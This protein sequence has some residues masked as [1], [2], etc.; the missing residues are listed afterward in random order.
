MVLWGSLWVRR[1]PGC[2][3]LNDR[4]SADTAA[5]QSPGRAR[6]VTRCGVGVVRASR[7]TDAEVERPIADR[8]LLS[9]PKSARRSRQLSGKG[10]DHQLA[11]QL[12]GEG[13]ELY[14]QAVAARSQ[15]T[16]T[17]AMQR[18]IPGG[19]R[20]VRRLPPVA[21]LI[22]PWKKT[23]CFE[24]AR[25]QFFADR[26]CQSQRV[27]RAAAQEVSQFT[28]SRSRRCSPFPD[29][30]VLDRVGQA[31]GRHSMLGLNL[32]D[33]QRPW[34][35]TFGHAVRIYDRMRLDDPTGKLADD[36]TIAAANALFA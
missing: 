31:K 18:F 20:Q 33:K 29:R 7:R 14:R 1:F 26:V 2:A 15:S 32:T 36:A 21:G 30:P 35:D 27:F 22:L 25:C 4:G 3:A 9:S 28:V 8:R 24:L 34:S 10:P 16:A 17:P 11:R 23:R 13:E 12:Y 6:A 5:S 19:Q